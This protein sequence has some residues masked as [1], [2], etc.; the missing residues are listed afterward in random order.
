VWESCDGQHFSLE[1]KHLMY[2]ASFFSF[3]IQSI[4][5]RYIQNN[6]LE[7]QSKLTGSVDFLGIADLKATIYV[8][9][10]HWLDEGAI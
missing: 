8:V 3:M 7:I 5:L 4:L 10:T 1:A 2:I 9:G 6:F